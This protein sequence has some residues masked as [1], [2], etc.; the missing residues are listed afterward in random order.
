MCPP[1]DFY[2]SRHLNGEDLLQGPRDCRPKWYQIIHAAT[3]ESLYRSHCMTN[4]YMIINWGPP[5]QLIES[6]PSDSG[7][8]AVDGPDS[9]ASIL[10]QR[11]FL[12]PHWTC[13]WETC[14]Q[15]PEIWRK[16][17]KKLSLARS[18]RLKLPN[19][20]S[21]TLPLE[22]SSMWP[23]VIHFASIFTCICIYFCFK[24]MHI[25]NRPCRCEID[26][27]RRRCVPWGGVRG[28]F[29]VQ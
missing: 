10:S 3:G 15:S 18:R 1:F 17:K 26:S 8:Y 16:K 13:I 12:S 7:P 21:L 24:L 27:E 4:R 6:C 20:S 9:R 28:I 25:W 29:L 11:R 14:R 22:K 5:K 19:G 23:K 2:Q